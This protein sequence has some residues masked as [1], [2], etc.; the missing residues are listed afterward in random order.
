MVCREVQREQRQEFQR[1]Q[2]ES[3]QQQRE[4]Q[5][6]RAGGHEFTHIMLLQLSYD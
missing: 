6:S 5:E 4:Q 1:Q 3:Q 2:R